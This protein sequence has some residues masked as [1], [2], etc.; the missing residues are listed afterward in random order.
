MATATPSRR[1][2][3]TPKNPPIYATVVLSCWL[4]LL[5][6]F[7]VVEADHGGRLTA[8]GSVSLGQ[9]EVFNSVIR[10]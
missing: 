4:H 3:R 2:D 7:D 5:I 6:G 10:S 1:S 9:R 8:M